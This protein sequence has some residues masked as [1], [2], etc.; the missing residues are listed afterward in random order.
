MLSRG[1]ATPRSPNALPAILPMYS[2]ASD[3]S[4]SGD[5]FAERRSYNFSY[6][7]QMS[8]SS[9]S[10]QNVKGFDFQYLIAHTAYTSSHYMGQL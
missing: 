8:R 10:I 6:V 9:G 4:A 1:S 3:E 5:D 7:A 2:M